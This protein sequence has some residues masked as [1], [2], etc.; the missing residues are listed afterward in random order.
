MD[1]GRRHRRRRRRVRER[2]RLA[3]DAG[4]DGVEVNAGQHS[5]VRQFLS[6]LT[7]HRDDAG[8]RRTAF[9]RE[10]LA[11]VRAAIGAGGVLGLRLSCDELAP[12]AGITPEVALDLA[13][14]LAASGV[15]Y[16][17]VT[18]GSIYSVETD[19]TRPPP[20][21]GVQRANWPA[22]SPGRRRC[23]SWPRDRS[24]TRSTPSGW[25]PTTAVAATAVEMTR[26]QIADP[27]LVAKLRRGEADRIRPCIRCN[28]TCQ[29]RDVRNP[30]VTCIGEPTSGRETEDPDWYA[31]ADV[32][33]AGHRRGRRCG[34]TRGGAGGRPARVTRCAWSSATTTS[35]GWPPPP[36]RTPRWCGGCRPRSPSTIG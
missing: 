36:G 7:N 29:V 9:A 26:A 32:A 18:R 30:L 12:W 17:V 3:V 34:R 35:A 10:V 21:G 6:G 33:R 11:A 22:P 13:A 24:S 28:Q 4:C 2:A 5:L 8:V 15:D 20:A 23:R 27:D 25:S 16:L 19:A 14:E 1:G 31:A